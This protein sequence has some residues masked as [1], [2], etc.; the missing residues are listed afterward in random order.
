MD[1][2]FFLQLVA[3]HVADLVEIHAARWAITRNFRPA[4]YA[5]VM[6]HVLTRVDFTQADD[7]FEANT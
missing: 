7:F 2:D 5:F 3:F 1:F 6:E 4:I